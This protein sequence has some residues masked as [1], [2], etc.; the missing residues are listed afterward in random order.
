LKLY[1][2]ILGEKGEM[3]GKVATGDF[4]IWRHKNFFLIAK[5]IGKPPELVI[6]ALAAGLI[7]I[8]RCF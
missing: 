8:A 3:I 1:W 7:K 6:E 4:Q 2:E 5:R